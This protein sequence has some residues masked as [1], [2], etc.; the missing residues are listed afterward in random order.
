[1]YLV[2]GVCLSNIHPDTMKYLR[3]LFKKKRSPATH[4]LVTMISDEK[5]NRKP[6]ALPVRYIP[7]RTIKDQFV[8]DLNKEL[9]EKMVERGLHVV[10]KLDRLYFE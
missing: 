5:R 6:Y 10:G 7:Y 1:M 8:R 2:V 9:K 3:N 4:V